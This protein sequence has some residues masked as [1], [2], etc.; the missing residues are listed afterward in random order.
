MSLPKRTTYSAP[1]IALLVGS[2]AVAGCASQEEL[3]ARAEAEQAARAQYQASLPR[4]SSDKECA[5]KW[6]A[7]RRWVLDNC[8]FKLQHVTDDYMETFNIRDP[9]STAMWCRVTKSPTS[10]TE[11]VIELENG[12]NNW[13][14]GGML[15]K[16]MEFNHYV[17]AAW[18]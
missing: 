11:Y 16:R 7:A 4:C 17:N 13:F 10:E 9:A 6:S 14:V 8:G 15:G 1:T 3:T 12:A 2:L 18:R 5:A